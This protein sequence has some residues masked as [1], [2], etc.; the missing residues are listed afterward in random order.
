MIDQKEFEEFCLTLPE[1]IRNEYFQWLITAYSV[2]RALFLIKKHEIKVGSIDVVEWC[3][4]LGMAGERQKKDD[5]VLRINL[6]TGVKD[7]EA[8]QDNINPDYPII[9]VEHTFGKGKK[10]ESSTL[11]IDGN[12]RLR[13]A[14]LNG[15][16]KLKAYFLPEK[17]AKK[18]KLNI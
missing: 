2:P 11:V 10:K 6:L 9:I 15:L 18:I 14:Y 3:K 4:A 8:M 5:N 1:D 12:K 7:D 17:L 13:K 16:T